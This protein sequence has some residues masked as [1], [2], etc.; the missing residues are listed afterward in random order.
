ME[1][2]GSPLAVSLRPLIATTVS[3]A[4]RPFVLQVMAD[5]QFPQDYLGGAVDVVQDWAVVG[6]PYANKGVRDVQSVTTVGTKALPV[7]GSLHL[8]RS[9]CVTR[10]PVC[11]MVQ[12][13]TR[14]T[15]T[16]FRS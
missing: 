13:P 5:D 2:D 11:P 16:R 9:I 14:G 10:S 12:A 7:R 6:A 4:T 3:S 15:K 1:L 8:S